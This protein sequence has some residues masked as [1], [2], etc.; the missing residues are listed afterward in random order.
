MRQRT[1]KVGKQWFAKPRGQVLIEML[2]GLA[3]LGLIAV[4]FLGAVYTNR[5]ATR[6][7][8]ERA[9]AQA[10]AQTQMEYLRSLPYDDTSDPLVYDDPAVLAPALLPLPAQY[11][12]Y[13]HNESFPTLFAERLDPEGDGS[14]DDDGLQKLT[15]TITHGDGVVLTLE[16]YKVKREEP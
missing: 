12:I 3:I 2:I 9:T 6:I 14:G 4:S 11:G 7:L 8:D 13:G 16:G 1:L 10:L 5:Q 15:V